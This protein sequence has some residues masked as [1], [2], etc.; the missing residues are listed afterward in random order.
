[1][2]KA[3][4]TLGCTA[5]I[6]ICLVLSA[7]AQETLKQIRFGFATK[8]VSPIIVNVL[9]PERL[10]YYRE[11]GLTVEAIPLG[12]NAAVMRSLEQK[13]VDFGTGVAAFQ[14][15]ILAR[16]EEL[17]LI[18]FFEFTYPFK[19]AMAVLPDSPAKSMA[20]LKGK[21]LA[22]SGFGMAEYPI[23]QTLMRLAGV[24]PEK[25]V[26][27]L[28]VGE[29]VTAGLA[30]QRGEADA[31]FYFDTGFG[32]IESAGIKLR[33][34][35]IPPGVPQIG[36]VFFSTHRDMLRDHRD[37]AI[38]F[39]RAAARAQIF[40][41]ENPEA[42]AYLFLQMFPEAAPK[43]VSI[44]KQVSAIMS[45]IVKRAPFYSPFDKSITK[46]GYIKESEWFDEIKFAGLEGKINNPSAMY[47]N[48]LIDDINRFDAESIRRQAGA[49]PLPYKAQ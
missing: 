24:D 28:A 32:T 8:A 40:I 23:G 33:Y 21:R 45:S 16:G 20:D 35:P 49:F 7:A 27:W 48:D 15:P 29:G 43:G 30:L 39:A 22:V 25:E 26:S 5:A 3:A 19:Y 11:E 14:L 38:G 17:P 9:I 34:L 2:E 47:T 12:S 1:M 46:W 44:D 6:T 4:R 41:Q 31:L 36:G 37:R 13:R 42:A 18:N 10:G